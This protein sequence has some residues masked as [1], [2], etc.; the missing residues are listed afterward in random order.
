MSKTL[1]AAINEAILTSQKLA[2]NDGVDA[3]NTTA[4]IIANMVKKEIADGAVKTLADTFK[5]TYYNKYTQKKLYSND[6]HPEDATDFIA[7]ET[8]IYLDVADKQ[9]EYDTVTIGEQKYVNKGSFDHKDKENRFKTV[10]IG[11]SGFLY[12]NAW[13]V[14]DG[15]LKVA[16]PFLYTNMDYATGICKINAG[17]LSYD[18]KVCDPITKTLSVKA[19][20]ILPEVKGYPAECKLAG[21]TVTVKYGHA[22][23]A[24]CFTLTDGETDFTDE[25]STIYTLDSTGNIG[26]TP[27]ETFSG[28]AF[29]YV[30]YLVKWVNGPVTEPTALDLDITL[31][32]P[33]VGKITIHVAGGTEVI[34]QTATE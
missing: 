19:A 3:V 16:V 1:L 20:E 25:N 5:T 13:K 18:V 7:D 22:T 4:Q 24:V 30:R 27:P 12:I 21:N 9:P 33:E 8:T 10:S 23:Q 6:F 11:N 34:E 26:I 17:G 32:V 28:K 2:E 15:V 29:S 31:V 14:V